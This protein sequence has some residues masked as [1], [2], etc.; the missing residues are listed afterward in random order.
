MNGTHRATLTP[1]RS[2]AAA[3]AG[4]LVL[5]LAA[6]LALVLLAAAPGPAAAQRAA[7]VVFQPGNYGTMLS[8]TI[9]G[10][11]YFDYR[12]RA[13]AGQE[14]F[15][16]LVVEATNGNGSAFFNILPPGS[17]GVAI[18]DG[19]MDGRSTTVRLPESGVY[20]IRVYLM[21]NDRD[22]GKTVGYRLEVSIQ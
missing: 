4:G 22:A 6:A 1:I 2:L 7:D 16:E 11:E 8:G 14:M 19:S 21:G 15:V 12:L 20:V 10:D 13:N 18:Y 5:V 17:D 3:L 9:V